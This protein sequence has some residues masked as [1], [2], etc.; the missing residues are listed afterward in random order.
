[1]ARKTI[2]LP[3]AVPFTE[4]F[5]MVWHYIFGITNRRLVEAGLFADPYNEKRKFKGF[6]PL[7]YKTMVHVRN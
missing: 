5:T 2:T 1:L 6:I 4:S 7:V 3:V